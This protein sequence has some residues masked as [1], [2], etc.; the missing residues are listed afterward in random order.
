MRKSF[1]A[2]ALIALVPAAPAFGHAH[3]VTSSPA[4]K[5][6]T[7]APRQVSVTFN[8]KLVP[9]FSRLELAM[10]GMNMDWP[11]KS[12]V[13]ADGKT[14]VATPKSPLMKG[15]YLMKWTAASADGHKMKGTIP[16][17]VK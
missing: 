3:V 16:F 5:A 6:V 1:A 8:E 10:P 13:S 15:N 2:L 9:A 14:L 12:A 4:T 17:Q 11:V 7:S